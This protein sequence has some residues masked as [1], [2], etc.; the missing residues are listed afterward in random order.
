MEYSTDDGYSWS[1]CGANMSQG[2][3]RWTDN[4]QTT[5]QFCIKA[6][7]SACA[8]EAQEVT[9]PARPNRPTGLQAVPATAAGND[10]RITG[11]STAME[12]RKGREGTR[13]PC[14]GTEIT[15]LAAGEYRVRYKATETAFASNEVYVAVRA[16]AP[17]QGFCLNNGN[18]YISDDGN[19]GIMVEQNRTEYT[20]SNG[21]IRITGNGGSTSNTISVDDVTAHI[22]LSN[23]KQDSGWDFPL[24]IWGSNVRL[25]LEGNNTMLAEY[26]AICVGEANDTGLTIDGT[27]TLT[28]GRADKRVFLGVVTVGTSVTID[29]GVLNIYAQDAAITGEDSSLTVNGGVICGDVS[30]DG[31]NYFGLGVSGNPSDYGSMNNITINGG[32]V[33][34]TGNNNKINTSDSNSVVITGG[35]VTAGGVNPAPTNRTDPVYAVTVE[36]I[37]S[38]TVDALLPKKGDAVQAYGAPART[39]TDGKVILYLPEGEYSGTAIVGG[40]LVNFT[41]EAK[42]DDTAAPSTVT[43]TGV[44]ITTPEGEKPTINGDGSV[45]I[46]DGSIVQTGDGPEITLPDGGAVKQDGTTTTTGGGK[47]QIGDTTVT[48]PSGGTIT[49]DR[50]GKTDIPQNSTVQTGDS[51]PEIKLP[52]GGSMSGGGITLPDGGSVQTGNP[53]TTITPPNG[54]PVI[55]SEGG[56]TVPGGSTVKP[57][58]GGPEITVGP[59]NSGTIGG[60]GGVTV[61]GGGKVTVKDDSGDIT[62]TLPSGGGTVKPKPNGTI[63]LPGGAKVEQGGQE[64]TVPDGGGTYHPEDGTVTKDVCTVTFDSQGGSA[65]SPIIVTLGEKATKPG[66]PTKSGY[67]F[68]GWYKESGCTTAWNFDTDTV[69]GDITLYAK[70]TATSNPGGNPGGNGGG[71]GTYTPTYPPTVERPSEGGGTPSTSPSNPKQGDTVTVKPRPDEG[72][73][74]DKITVTDRNGKPVEVTKKPDGTY[75]FKQPSGKVTIKVTYQPIDRPWNNPFTDVSEGD[76]YYEAVQFVQERGLMNGYEDGRFGPNDTLSRAQ[77]AQ[78]LFNKEGRPGVNYL[79]DFS[80]VAGEAWYTEAIRWATSQGIVGGYGNGTFGPNDPITREQL[81]V[82]L[83]RYSGSPA[84]TNKELHFNDTDEISPFALEALRCAV[85]NG[86]LNGYGDGRLGPQGQATRAQVAQMLKNFI[87]DQENKN[88]T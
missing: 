23:V 28:I 74:V 59:G 76:W 21:E 49:T 7:D 13:T 14:T 27:G 39:T 46:P 8:S 24:E 17:E 79:M 4:Q 67:T 19:G 77:L 73:E 31:E 69:T 60:D 16:A 2:D 86:I 9:I 5:V 50:D 68:D 61:P 82:M 40:K 25:T 58:D 52:D 63:P 10:G 37:G 57:G 38:G 43:D 85:E 33:E 22:T 29:G 30:G 56:V 44:T 12:Y 11:V 88:N 62:I 6:T 65:V 55:P 81:A 78:I 35:S 70:W 64:I 3:F 84:A 32:T 47:M 26:E 75:T 20:V 83:W 80:D 45:T 54:E 48:P 53:A 51:S 42:S 18:I 15:G 36:G 66:N 87:E 34:L 71:G 1:T 72:Y 41:C